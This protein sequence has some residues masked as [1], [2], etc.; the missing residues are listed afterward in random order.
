MGRSP[1]FSAL[2]GAL[3]LIHR[4]STLDKHKPSASPGMWTNRNSI[5]KHTAKF[6]VKQAKSGIRFPR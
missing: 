1:L 6:F 5:Q 4:I 3:Q 2:K